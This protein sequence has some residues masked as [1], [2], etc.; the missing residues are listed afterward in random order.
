MSTSAWAQRHPRIVKALTIVAIA[1]TASVA[2]GLIGFTLLYNMVQLP[3]DGPLP[4]VSTAYDKD[5]KEISTLSA[6]QNRTSITL[7][8]VS[9]FMKDAVVASED[10]EF[11]QHGGVSFF[12]VTRAA[13]NNLRGGSR[14]GGSTITQQLVKN[15][16]LTSEQTMTRKVKEAVLATKVERVMSK[17]EILERYLNTIYFG[18]GAYGV[19]AASQAYFGT[20]ASKLTLEQAAYLTAA[21]KLPARTAHPDR[22]LTVRNQVLGTM[23]VA[24]KITPEDEA[25]TKELP[26][27]TTDAKRVNVKSAEAAFFLQRVEQEIQQKAPKV[28]LHSGGYKVYTTY[29]PAMGRK[30][31]QVIRSTLNRDGDPQAALVTIDDSG[32]IRALYG[33]SDMGKLQVNLATGKD[34]GGSGRQ[35]GSTFKPVVLASYLNNGGTLSSAF[36]APATI[37]LVTGGAPWTVRNYEPKDYGNMSVIDATAQSTNTVYAQMIEQVGAQSIV[38]TAKSLGIGGDLPA[39]P[40]VG[41]G[42]GSVSPLGMATGYSVFMNEGDLIEPT[43]LVRVVGPSKNTVYSAQKKSRRVIDKGVAQATTKALVSVVERGTG[44]AAA[45]GRPVAGKTGTTSDY[46]DAWFVGYTPY[47]TTA[48]WVGYPDDS[49]KKMENVHGAKV[50]GGSFPAQMFGAYMRD[51]VKGTKADGFPEPPAQFDSGTTSTST[52]TSTSSTTPETTTTVA[53]TIAPTTSTRLATTTAA[54]RTTTS[55]VTTAPPARGS[56]TGGDTG[57][58]VGASGSP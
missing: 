53:T 4:Q 1:A 55:V 28:D 16:Y 39:T 47:L 38:S 34:G 17:D 24:K 49:S 7:D 46:V 31:D 8:K 58:V 2:I 9:P 11:Y 10:H 5:G 35:P 37:D 51:A 3:K 23:V 50:S 22:M 54:Q 13:V 30:A 18:R 45:I 44:K 42:S 25:K 33:G 6:S 15:S 41:L 19:E 29:D 52:S 26:I 40:A 21:L 14:Q 43:T 32:A 56:P 20:N 36:R 57:G 27:K 12:G 48:I